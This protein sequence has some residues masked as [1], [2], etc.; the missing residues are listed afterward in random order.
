M[1]G[2]IA[3]YIHPTLTPILILVLK[4]LAKYKNLWV[5]QI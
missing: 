5:V 1:D 4:Y 3:T 2:N